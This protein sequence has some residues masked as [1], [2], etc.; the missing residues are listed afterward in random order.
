MMIRLKVF[1]CLA[2]A[3]GA[4]VPA[5]AAER[6]IHIAA[7]RSVGFMWQVNDGAGYRWDI[8]SNGQVSD[9]TNDAYDGGMQLRVGG[10]Y[11]SNSGQGRL[12]ADGREVEIGPWKQGAI[13]VYR[14]VY[15]DPKVGYCRWI[16]LFENPSGETQSIKIQYYS[17]LG[18]SVTSTYTTTGG[19]NTTAK[20]WGI[21]T[22]ETSSSSRPIIVHV[23]GTRGSRIKPT[24]RYTRNN[25]SVY[26][27]LDLKVPAG[28]TVAVCT[29]HAQRRPMSKAREFLKAFKPRRELAKVPTA[30]RRIIVNMGGATLTLGNIDL[31]R[32]EKHDLAVLRNQNELLGK[33]L[34][35][36]FDLETFYGKLELPAAR[37]VGINVPAPDD[38]HVQVI[39]VDGQVVAGKLLNAPLRI[40]LTNGNEMS[41]P[42]AKLNAATFALSPQRPGEIKLS[43]P[44]VLLRAG[45]Q[46]SFQKAD[47]DCTFQTL[48]GTVK[49]NADDLQAIYFDTPEGGLH[50]AVFRNGSTLSGLLASGELKLKLRLGPELKIP[51][52]LVGQVAFPSEEIDSGGLAELTLRNED[53]LFGRIAEDSLTVT[54]QYGKV[55]VKPAEIGEL[56]VPPTGAL[57]QVRIKLHNG[58]TVTGKLV[59]NTIRF[60]IAP[61][62]KLPIFLGHVVRITRPGD[63]PSAPDKTPDKKATDPTTTTT[64]PPPPT[65]RTTPTVKPV[66]VE[67]RAEPAQRAAAAADARAAVKAENLAKLKTLTAELAQLQALKAKL[68]AEAKKLA[69]EKNNAAALE[70]FKKRADDVD[71]KIASLR[72]A[73]QTLQKSMRMSPRVLK[74]RT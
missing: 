62:P 17:N 60:Q 73:I 13:Q 22:G 19:T 55:T 65:T 18:L 1:G 56:L 51:R 36:R 8:S 64:P 38:P 44:T 66:P 5:G 47:L 6:G 24:F 69:K 4:A 35:E 70:K 57:G 10:T 34:N 23:F 14:R 40:R 9:G 61:G 53:Q 74:T 21:V 71:A 28:K 16:D 48:Y 15:V 54:T 63:K 52:H 68:D 29:F 11:F 67:V 46:L 30:L 45:Q 58:T 12:S 2:V 49:L 37:V 39:L 33:I 3:V 27:D 25:D 50:R 42:P 43:E 72:D 20:D 26:Q 41:L 31:P 59:G 7:G 32:H